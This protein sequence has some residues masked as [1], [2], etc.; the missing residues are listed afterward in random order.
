MINQY[1]R[2]MLHKTPKQGSNKQPET[3]TAVCFLWSCVTATSLILKHQVLKSMNGSAVR[4][5]LE[6][7]AGVFLF[8]ILMWSLSKVRP[9]GKQTELA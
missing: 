9:E 1:L 6:A 4:N 2:E 8:L 7:L 3:S 5:K